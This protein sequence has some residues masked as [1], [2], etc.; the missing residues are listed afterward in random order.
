[1][2][3]S[4][5]VGIIAIIL[6]PLLALN[7]QSR[8]NVKREKMQRRVAVFRTLMATR[9]TVLSFQHVEALNSI[10]VEFYAVNTVV[11]VWRRYYNH[12]IHNTPQ[13]EFAN[14]AWE[15]KQK[16]L[17]TNLLYEMAV[18]LEYGFDKSVIER[19]SYFPNAYGY[20]EQENQ[21]IRNSL[22][23]LLPALLK[24]EYA[25]PVDIASKSESEKEGKK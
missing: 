2:L 15:E 10:D 8:L 13:N 5:L 16:E 9:G 18:A 7:V 12:L 20:A 24:R 19:A 3:L 11:E 4:D 23:Q 14:A 17:L 25:V 21:T 1:M 6:A 22:S